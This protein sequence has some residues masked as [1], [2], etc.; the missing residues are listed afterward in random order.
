MDHRA[1]H[2]AA[3]APQAAEQIGAFGRK[4]PVR[5]LEPEPLLVG[6]RLH[7]DDLTTHLGVVG[8]AE[9][10]AEQMI[11]A[12]LVGLEPQGRVAARQDVLL[13]PQCRKVEA[14][15]HVLGDHGELDRPVRRDVQLIDL[16]LAAGMLEFPHP[17]LGKDVH[18][19]GAGGR[20]VLVEVQLG[21]PDEEDQ[22]QRERNDRP[23]DLQLD[24]AVRAMLPARGRSL[25]VAN[26]KDQEQHEHRD[27]QQADQDQQA[28]QQQVHLAGERRGDRGPERHAHR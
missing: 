14:V 16:A 13:D 19:E 4:R 27:G 9:L 11:G 15:D 7:D 3:A 10:R 6:C 24:V 25:P 2:V 23:G 18:L 17:L 5:G 8:A 12:G 28:G 26:G 20:I 22:A 1:V 21:R